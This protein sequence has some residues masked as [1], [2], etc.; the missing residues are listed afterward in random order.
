MNPGRCQWRV[1]SAKGCIRT[2]LSFLRFL[3]NLELSCQK[4]RISPRT[5]ACDEGRNC[6]LGHEFRSVGAVRRKEISRLLICG[7]PIS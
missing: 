6:R 3:P 4:A 5:A 7:S 2:V 1:I